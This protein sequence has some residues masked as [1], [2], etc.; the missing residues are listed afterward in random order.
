MYVV[1][2]AFDRE[3]TVW[4]SGGTERQRSYLMAPLTA[5]HRTSMRPSG[6]CRADT[7]AG[8]G[9]LICA[10]EPAVGLLTGSCA[11]GCAE[12]SASIATRTAPKRPACAGFRG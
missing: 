10:L 4:G 2:A 9:S 8:A 1:S 6:S 3:T 11:H 5:V 7:E 12:V